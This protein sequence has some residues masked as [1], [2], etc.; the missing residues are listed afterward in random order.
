MLHLLLKQRRCFAGRVQWAWLPVPAAKRKQVIVR[1]HAHNRGRGGKLAR[2]GAYPYQIFISTEEDFKREHKSHVFIHCDVSRLL[3]P[4]CDLIGPLWWARVL[5]R[6]WKIRER[7]RERIHTS[8]SLNHL[9]Q[10]TCI[11]TLQYTLS[12]L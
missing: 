10:H 12:L 3:V 8:S 4:G 11:S 9:V 7:E 6:F 5:T 1:R 2:L